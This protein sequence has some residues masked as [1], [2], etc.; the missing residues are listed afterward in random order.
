MIKA[1]GVRDGHMLM[2]AGLV[3]GPV[4]ADETQ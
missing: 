2:D 1:I 3:L 4:A